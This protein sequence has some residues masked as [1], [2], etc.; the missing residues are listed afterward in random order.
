MRSGR[1]SFD[2]VYALFPKLIFLQRSKPE[3]LSGGERQMLA[4]ARALM[5]K[6][7]MLMLDEPSAGLSPKLV[8]DVFTRLRTVRDTGTAIVLVEQNVRAALALADRALVLVEGRVAHEGPANVLADDSRIAAL[9]L[10]GIPKV[11]GAAA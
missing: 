8:G 9:Y 11:A 2:E 3:S 6:P 10:G 4:I 1:A 7:R 5:P